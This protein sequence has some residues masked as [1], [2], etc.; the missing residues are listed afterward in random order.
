LGWRFGVVR[1][2]EAVCAGGAVIAAAA[3][4]APDKVASLK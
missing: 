2:D 1:V 4:A 3:K